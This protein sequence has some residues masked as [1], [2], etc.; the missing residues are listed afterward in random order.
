M[1]S[2]IIKF[3]I[4]DWMTEANKFL[5]PIFQTAHGLKKGENDVGDHGKNAL[6]CLLDGG[7][8]QT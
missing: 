6:M 3:V 8:F 7:K 1:L 5:Y 4:R 2:S